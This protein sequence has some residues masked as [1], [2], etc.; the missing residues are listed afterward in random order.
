MKRRAILAWESFWPTLIVWLP[1][2]SVLIIT[3]AALPVWPRESDC[4]PPR[5]QTLDYLDNPT[6]TLAILV[7]VAEFLIIKALLMARTYERLPS[8]ADIA[9]MAEGGETVAVYRK[10]HNGPRDFLALSLI[11]AN[12]AFAVL[13]LLSIVLFLNS[14][15]MVS[16]PGEVQAIQNIAR[17]G[18]V[19]V[20]IWGGYQLLSVP[21]LDH[22][23]AVSRAGLI[24]TAVLIAQ[25]VLVY[26]VTHDDGRAESVGRKW[27]GID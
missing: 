25:A 26:V 27:L 5:W 15:W 24:V 11:S 6:V 13:Y 16:Y 23:P 10:K 21:R 1:L 8:R 17:V 3:E 22:E 2:V 14:D 19:I 4:K 18:L 12:V 9:L 7:I 20:L